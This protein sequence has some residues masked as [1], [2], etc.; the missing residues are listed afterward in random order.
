MR[1]AWRAFV[2]WARVGIR[3]RQMRPQ[4]HPARWALVGAA[5]ML[6]GFDWA[7]SPTGDS[8]SLIMGIAHLM[9]IAL[10]AVAPRLGAAGI[11]LIELC[12]CFHQMIGGPSRLWGICLAVGVTSY[13]GGA[14]GAVLL[15]TAI[16]STL[17]LL[18]YIVPQT[19]RYDGMSAGATVFL[20]STM[21]VAAL[22]GYAARSNIELRRK[23]ERR[24]LLE[25]HEQEYERQSQRLEL[26]SRMH[27]ALSGRLANIIMYA[28]QPSHVSQDDWDTVRQEA[29]SALDELHAIIDMLNGDESEPGASVQANILLHRLKDTCSRQENRLTEQGLTGHT[30]I[31]D[32]GLICKPLESR[33][34]LVVELLDEMFVNIGKHA[35]AAEPYQLSVTLYDDRIE[36]IQTNRIRSDDAPS[37]GGKGI[38]LYADRIRLIHGEMSYERQ[39]ALW[40]LHASIPLIDVTLAE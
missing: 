18:Q 15:A 32:W 19:P 17:Q 40:T 2:A 29:Q 35:S 36:I 30:A 22:L 37:L 23:D 4:D 38:G 27:D 11:A 6:S 10:I 25:L 33:I 24:H 14:L 34:R 3:R 9:S 7:A 20:I 31:K 26:A 12:C 5:L 1:N 39:E 13:L 16:Y 8:Y 21:L 28:Q